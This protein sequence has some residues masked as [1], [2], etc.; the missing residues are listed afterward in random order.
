[1]GFWQSVFLNKRQQ[2]LKREIAQVQYQI[3]GNWYRGTINS[4]IVQ[5]AT[6][7]V[8]INLPAFGADN[9]ITAMRVYDST[10]DLAG[11]QAL[12]IAR[13]A[14]QSAD[15]RLVLTLQEN[16][17]VLNLNSNSGY[18]LL[19]DSVSTEI[20]L[21][22]AP[23]V[24]YQ[25][26]NQVLSVNLSFAPAAPDQSTEYLLQFKTGSQIPEVT[27]SGSVS[28]SPA[29]PVFAANK[30]YTLAFVPTGNAYHGIWLAA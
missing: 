9:V 13:T 27:V 12:A 30:T 20:N 6:L 24:M 19:A 7:T 16:E 10:G 29:I 5:A 21:Q 15:L 3:A 22:L 11:Q 8:L 26:T 1:M 28:W 4:K 14:T 23:N 17:T 25:F 2:A 18:L